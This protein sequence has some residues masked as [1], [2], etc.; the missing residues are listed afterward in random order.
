MSNVRSIRYLLTA[1]LIC[2][3]AAIPVW[4]QKGGDKKPADDPRDKPIKAKAEPD[5]V[6]KKWISNEGSYIATEAEKRAYKALKTNEERENFIETFW[7]M[8]DPSPDTEENEYR[9][10]YYERLAYANEHFASGTPGWKT[11]RGR[12]YITWGKPDSVDSH[13]TG[14]S[15]D[16]PS[17]EGGG[18]TTTYPFE[19][20][21][22]RHLDNVG[23][24]LEIEFVDP[25]GTGEYRLARDP[26]EKD[27]LLHIPGAGQTTAEQMG[28]ANK[29]DRI[30][31]LAGAQPLN[32]QREQD[33][34]FR[35]MEVLIGLSHPPTPKFSDLDKLLVGDSGIIDNYPLQFDL[36]IDFFRQ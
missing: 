19:T 18:S 23:D 3:F 2:G 36:R 5:D 16:R 1:I 21:Y 7:R 26:N 34:V 20:W 14:G 22:Y 32:Y 31:G 6:F 11:D 17:Y 10:A 4:S 24:G 9:E 12:I 8:R 27:A 35:R 13:P 33:T 25:T 15:Y 29:A 30:G 28:L